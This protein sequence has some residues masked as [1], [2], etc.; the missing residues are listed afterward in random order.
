MN[1]KNEWDEMV[2]AVVVQ[3]P[4]DKVTEDEVVRAS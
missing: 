2:D 4:I 3:G 1:E